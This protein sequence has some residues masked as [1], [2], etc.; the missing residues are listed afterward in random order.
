[1]R[2]TIFHRTLQKKLRE[3]VAA[4][5]VYADFRSGELGHQYWSNSWYNTTIAS[6]PLYATL[7]AEISP[8]PSISRGKHAYAMQ[9]R[10]MHAT[11]VRMFRDSHDTVR[12]KDVPYEQINHGRVSGVER[13]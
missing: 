7:S 2:N 1:M 3:D 4:N 5:L 8:S 10:S 9:Q 11:Y 6:P 12:N 13:P